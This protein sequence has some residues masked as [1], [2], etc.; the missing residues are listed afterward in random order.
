MLRKSFYPAF[1][2]ALL[3]AGLSAQ[4]NL[5]F[6]DGAKVCFVGNSITQ[7]GEYV[8][9][10]RGFYATRYPDQ[11]VEFINCGISG[12]VTGGILARMQPDI[13]VHKPDYAVIMIGMNDVNRPLY[14]A[15][16][17]GIDSIRQKKETALA[18]YREN[19]SQI[20]KYLVDNKVKV[21]LQKPSIYDQ[22]AKIP[23]ENLNGV[24]DALKT[25]AGYMQELANKYR[26]R[27]VDYW[28]IMTDINK[29]MQATDSSFTIVGKDRVHPASPGHFTMA[30]Q[31]LHSTIGALPANSISLHYGSKKVV[32][33]RGEKLTDLEFSKDLIRFTSHPGSLPYAMFPAALPALDLVPFTKEFNTELLKVAGLPKGNYRLTISDSIAGEFS[34]GQL[35]KGINLSLLNTPQTRQ[36]KEVLDYCLKMKALESDLRQL[37]HMEYRTLFKLPNGNIKDSGIA[38]LQR[39]LADSATKK[40]ER[41]PAERY[42]KNKPKEEELYK[43]WSRMQERLY[44]INKPGAVRVKIE[45]I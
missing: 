15:R 44:E 9:Y 41:G 38:I 4:N 22:T 45:K 34:A 13:M 40:N 25:C 8:H 17:N 33:T 16:F 36:A 26:L 12:D 14:A 32:T 11:K 24:N 19:L 6:P 43:E 21:I 1:C 7:A 2:L 35:D 27:T 29:K 23:Q 10:I 42:L 20:V 18:T 37:R 39:K 31:F 3:P 30:Y 28:S 5:V